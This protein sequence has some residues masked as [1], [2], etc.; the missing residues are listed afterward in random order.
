MFIISLYT[1]IIFHM[2]K[3]IFLVLSILIN[4]LC[5]IV[6]TGIIFGISSLFNQDNALVSN[7]TFNKY[8]NLAV[9]FKTSLYFFALGV[10]PAYFVNLKVL[11]V[12]KTRKKWQLNENLIFVAPVL[13]F[14]VPLCIIYILNLLP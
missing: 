6:I 2:K 7:L 1:Y 13:A 8:L 11:Q 10:I 9:S 4:I 14:I 3:V 12:L 5:S